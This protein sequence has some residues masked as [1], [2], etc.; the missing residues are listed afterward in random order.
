MKFELIGIVR[1]PVTK[2]VDQGWGEIVS[3]IHIDK[4]YSLGL[5]GLEEFTHIIV[6]F[7]MH[8]ATMSLE[9]DIIRRP[10]GRKDMPKSGIFA[11]RAKHR[12]NPIGITAVELISIKENIATV[13]RLDAIDETPVL[14][15]KPYFP[16]FDRVDAKTP[17]W[18]NELMK[19][20]F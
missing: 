20:Y 1:S 2:K 14:D 10:Q 18:V 5:R 3:E 7:Y 16:I 8:K 13:K 15:I 9:T 11:Q 19:N 12:P 6:I 17:N 4:K